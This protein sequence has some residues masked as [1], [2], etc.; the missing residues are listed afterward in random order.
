MCE[1]IN[2]NNELIKITI[3]NGMD[4]DCT[5]VLFDCYVC[6]TVPIVNMRTNIHGITTEMLT[7][8]TNTQTH[9]TNQPN[10]SNGRLIKSFVEIQAIL[11]QLINSSTIIVGHGIINDLKTLQ[12]KH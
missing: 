3:I 5:N 4:C 6:P 8:Q 1:T 12:L 10:G 9:A 7:R 2:S 11:L